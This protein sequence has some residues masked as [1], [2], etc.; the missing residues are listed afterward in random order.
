M[1]AQTQSSVI[2]HIQVGNTVCYLKKPFDSDL[3]SSVLSD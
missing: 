1:S 3:I 2:K